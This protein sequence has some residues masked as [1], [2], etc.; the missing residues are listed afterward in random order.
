MA[1]KSLAII[2]LLALA[3]A[4]CSSGDAAT[5]TST[6]TS[7]TTPAPTAVATSS[8]VPGTTSTT[9]GIT[10]TTITTTTISTTTSTT[11][12]TSEPP[13]PEDGDD[14]EVV[15]A[16]IRDY[17]SIDPPLTVQIVV[18]QLQGLGDVA[19]QQS[20]NEALLAI[21]GGAEGGFISDV[22]QYVED[23]EPTPEAP[24]SSLDMFYSVRFV[25]AVLLSIRFDSSTYFQG[26]ANPGNTVQTLNIDL[27]TGD[28]LLLSDLFL[29]SEWAFAL[30]TLLRQQI[31]DEIYQGDPT[32]LEGWVDADALV[33]SQLFAFGDSG[34]EFSFQEFEVGP[35]VLGAPTVTLPYNAMGVYIDPDGVL[36]RVADVAGGD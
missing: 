23:V 30:D 20:V 17:A 29:G 5:P 18:P 1:G 35:G 3:A 12:S 25:D 36:G 34:L 33:I 32:Q 19:I 13:G 26:A 15:A 8:G 22:A 28:E 7:T 10:T 21:A 4:S 16:E 27:T 31:T 6:S 2:V 9:L 14:V 11:T 24:V